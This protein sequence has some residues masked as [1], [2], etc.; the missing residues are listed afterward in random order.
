MIG[1]NAGGREM[2]MAGALDAPALV[3]T[4]DNIF[5]GLIYFA[6]QL[7]AIVLTELTTKV[8]IGT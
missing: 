7:S 8:W 5:A 3:K 2:K 4:G 1:S 6:A